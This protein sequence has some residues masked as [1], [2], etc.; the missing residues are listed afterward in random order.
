MQKRK[1]AK[2]SEEKTSEVQD[3]STM[4]REDEHPLAIVCSDIH[5]SHLP[6]IARTGEAN[7]Y[8]VMKR[9]LQELKA[10]KKELD[11]IPL[12]CAGDVFDH[13]RSPPE[14]INFALKYLP[15]M[16]AITGQHDLPYHNYEDLHRSAYWTLVQAGLIYHIEPLESQRINSIDVVGLPWG[17]SADTSKE[18]KGDLAVIHSYCWKGKRIPG[19]TT[20]RTHHDSWWKDLKRRGFKAALFGDN[21]HGFLANNGHLL[22]SG[23][24]FR[25]KISESDYQPKVGILLT[26][27]RFVRVP[28]KSTELDVILPDNNSVITALENMQDNPAIARLIERLG[29]ITEV[30]YDFRSV[31]SDFLKS[32]EAASISSDVIRFITSIIDRH[33]GLTDGKKGK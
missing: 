10:L 25:R 31:V 20:D 26:S 3:L 28:I 23:T 13:W 27:Y 9:Q 8:G 22:N 24:F 12:I 14:L 29:N 7:W 17:A 18:F 6:P 16:Y 32:R 1:R 15:E 30:A 4:W 21:H 5:L 19:L 11:P 2:T 33:G